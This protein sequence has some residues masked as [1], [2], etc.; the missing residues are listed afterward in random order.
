MLRKWLIRLVRSSVRWLGYDIVQ[1][2]IGTHSIPRQE[3]LMKEYQIDIV[4]DVGANVG[5]YGRKLI[6]DMN[7]KGEIYSFEPMEKEFQGLKNE[8]K[9]F[10]QWTVFNQALGDKKQ[11]LKINVSEN[12]VSSSILGI[13]DKHTESAPQSIYSHTEDVSVN[14]LDNVI[15]ENNLKNKNIFLKLDVQGFEKQALL[16]G[17]DSLKY[18]DTIQVEISLVPLYDGGVVFEELFD[19]L[20]AQGYTLVAIENGFS[21]KTTGQM[22]QMDGIFHRYSK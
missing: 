5:L 4:L 19:M 3:A 8:S 7:Y 10:G 14:T 2:S 18:I 9:I 20:R 17:A 16:G 12:S 11:K 1:F 13:L 21:H 22:L 15:K 6:R